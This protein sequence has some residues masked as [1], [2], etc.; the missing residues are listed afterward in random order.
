MRERDVGTQGTWGTW[1]AR[2]AVPGVLGL[3]YSE[4]GVQY[5]ECSSR[6]TLLGVL[7][8][9]GHLEY[10]TLSAVFGVQSALVGVLAQRRYFICVT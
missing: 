7:G 10:S 2:S 8:V 4:L 9:P 1:S 3:P 6:S 5:S